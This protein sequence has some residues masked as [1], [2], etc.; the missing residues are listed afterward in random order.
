MPK[1]AL[2]VDDSRTVRALMSRL[3]ERL[4]FD[5]QQAPDGAAALA[6]LAANGSVDV[7]MVD[8]NMPTLDGL[9]FLREARST[10]AY[11]DMRVVMV[12]TETEI[13]R[14]VEALDAGAD[15]YLM[16]PFTAEALQD[17]LALL[18][19]AEPTT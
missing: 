19:L 18:G 14:M 13:D 16:K 12:T 6:H 15:E 4:G 8:W 11:R 7:A 3:L 10:N 2:V 5:V 17:K 1:Q 9:G